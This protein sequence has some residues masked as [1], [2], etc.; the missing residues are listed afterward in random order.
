MVVR[1]A[2][3]GARRTRRECHRVLSSGRR[4]GWLI[5]L[6]G[7]RELPYAAASTVDNSGGRIAPDGRIRA[8]F[9]APGRN[10]AKS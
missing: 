8:A 1:A 3:T 6:D 9:L 4:A 5:S 7:S 10:G 2:A